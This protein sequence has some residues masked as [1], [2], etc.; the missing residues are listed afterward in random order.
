MN[1]ND[2]LKSFAKVLGAETKFE[3]L[4]E[5]RL[6]EKRMLESLGARFGV[7]LKE[8]VAKPIPVSLLQQPP[9]ITIVEK[10][11]EEAPT[12][13]EENVIPVM[14][15]L[16]V[17]T[18]VTKSVEMIAKASPADVQKTVDSISG[19]L[20]KEVDSL[21]KSVTD[22]HRFARNTSQMGGG[23][24]VNL[25]YL[26]DVA[27]DSIGDNK[28]M[29]Y[30]ASTKS[31]EFYDFVSQG[32]Y[33]GD[34]EIVNNHINLLRPNNTNIVLQPTGNGYVEVPKLKMP[35]G[36]L[37]QEEESIEVIV[38][39]LILNATTDYSTG[40]GDNLLIGDYGLTRGIAHPWIV[41]EFTTTPAPILQLDDVISGEGIP[42]GSTVLFVGSGIY[43]KYV[44]TNIAQPLAIPPASYGITVAIVRPLVNATL[45]MTTDIN[46]DI[47]LHPGANGRIVAHTL[48]SPITTG[49][50]DL[51]TPL[52]RWKTLWLG[53]GSIYLTDET[54]GVD[55]RLTA[56]DGNFVI[57]G[58]AGL[59]VGE[60][61]FHD[62]YVLLAN[63]AREII[64]GNTDATGY[65]TL[66]RPIRIV[67]GN[68]GQDTF[69]ASRD[70]R[71]ALHPP[72]IPSG[73]IGAL[74]IIGSSDR[75]Y[76]PVINPGGMLH[77]TGYANTGA[78][79]TM[80]TF[81]AAPGTI[82]IYVGRRARG[83]A[84]TPT[85]TQNNDILAR[86]A[87]LGYAQTNYYPASS[88]G[89][90][91]S[92]EFIASENHS[93]TN[94]GT[95]ADIFTI[96]VGATSRQLSLSIDPVG[97]TT[98]SATFS[99][100]VYIGNVGNTTNLH[101]SGGAND[102]IL[103]CDGANNLV[104][105][106]RHL[107]GPWTPVMIPATGSNVV[108]TVASATYVKNGPMVNMFFDITVN[109]MGTASGALRLDG[110]PFI[111]KT[112]V[113]YV[114]AV[115]VQFYSNLNVADA[116]S[117]TGGVLASNNRADMWFT[118]L[119]GQRVEFATLLALDVK[120]GTRLVGSI[121]YGTDF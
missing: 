61:T 42:V 77:I 85:P 71:V 95:R 26:D 30:V 117:I 4:E 70:G 105:T 16:P 28:F 93:N 78:R 57:A 47:S 34:F 83:T 86:Y 43:S 29:R 46:T 106:P 11:I 41:Y 50:Y 51:G 59:Q 20:R 22:L 84:N 44:I 101:I 90:P 31:F 36:S 102:A 79:V 8:E 60:F 18:M 110:F 88:T 33:L 116:I 39:D 113:N 12:A 118:K 99:N 64:V 13:I 40:E 7:G 21:K 37:I 104:W 38:A 53:A 54:L 107:D 73:D 120:V 103:V 115:A 58:G 52:R 74:S 66:N 62:N 35:V 72:L 65:L 89:A 25:R 19:S 3:E 14:P 63:S 108:F 48:I 114:G 109:S 49:V 98:N 97:I 5:K 91:A 81:G 55:Q 45:S 32:A 23:G 100:N 67:S 92:L 10:K 27:R 80:D 112:G 87:G 75:S 94:F 15:Q 9:V 121:I 76:Q 69:N 17:A 111:S 2:F 1:E 82:P 119:N 96:P 68:T 24:E 56:I 6:K